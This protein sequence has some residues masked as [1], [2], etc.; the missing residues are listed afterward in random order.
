MLLSNVILLTF[1]SSSFAYFLQP[2]A[3]VIHRSRF[4][5]SS[6]NNIHETEVFN[7]F[8]STNILSDSSSTVTS[9]V[10]IENDISSKYSSV[11]PVL[12]IFALLG[13]SGAADASVDAVA[14]P[15]QGF[16][17]YI[18]YCTPA[19]FSENILQFSVQG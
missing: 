4:T 5:L 2:N 10:P 6:S 9:D 11:L 16:Q 7:P 3:R 19:F 1:L 17:L 14:V 8:L 12:S 15:L 13:M 18:R